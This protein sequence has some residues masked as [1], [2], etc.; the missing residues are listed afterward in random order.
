MKKAVKPKKTKASE[1][2]LQK[3]VAALIAEN[4]GLKRSVKFLTEQ[5]DYFKNQLFAVRTR[6]RIASGPEQLNYDLFGE[7]IAPQIEEAPTEKITYQRKKRKPSQERTT[8]PDHLE[9][10]VEV[11]ELT[12]DDCNC[13]HCGTT[14]E[15]FG[16]DVTEELEIIPAKVIVR[17]IVRCK[18]KCPKDTIHGVFRAPTVNRIVPKGIAGPSLLNHILISKYIDHQPLE[19]ISK[20]I[21]RTGVKISKSTMSDWMKKLS[22]L[23]NPLLEELKNKALNSRILNCDE[24][25]LLVTNNSISKAKINGYLWSYIGDKKWVWFNWQAGRGRAGPLEILQDFTGEYLQSDGYQVYKSMQKQLGYKNIGCW[26][27]ARRKFVEAHDA[28]YPQAKVAVAL[29]AKLYKVEKECREQNLS[30]DEIFERRQKESL[31]VLAEIKA[32]LDKEVITALPKSAMGKAVYYA[33]NQWDTLQR[34]CEDGELNIDNNIVE[35]AIRPVA[36][37][38]K[39]WLFAG[40]PEGAEWAAGFYS[41]IETAKLH[42]LEPSQHLDQ[43]IKAL[44]DYED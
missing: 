26:A 43:V 10:R 31:P 25:T 44:P 3:Q 36:L 27:H 4:L 1:A 17:R 30:A 2:L 37:G 39:N 40:S 33:L 15:K 24:T 22:Q 19:R 14:L 9:R 5:R 6:D 29:I 34:Y 7:D 35:R 8:L 16:E 28:D 23:L 32:Y 13:T 11:I 18:Y 12:G 38:R 21:A 41:L 20:S 42:G